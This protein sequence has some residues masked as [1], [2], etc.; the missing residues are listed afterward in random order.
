MITL[1]H[2][3]D[4]LPQF[5]RSTLKVCDGSA[6][7]NRRVQRIMCFRNSDL[8]TS[9][10]SGTR[11]VVLCR[12]KGVTWNSRELLT[13]G[14]PRAIGGILEGHHGAIVEPVVILAI[15]SEE[16]QGGNVETP[17]HHAYPASSSNPRVSRH[18]TRTRARAAT[19]A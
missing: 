19:R 17:P 12:R 1:M 16:G 14:L 8:W 9:E 10:I 15:R 3:Q 18:C 6:S 7:L 5:R 4:A 11:D 2:T 13:F